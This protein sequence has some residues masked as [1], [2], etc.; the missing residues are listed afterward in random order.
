MYHERPSPGHYIFDAAWLLLGLVVGLHLPDVDSRLRWLV[1]SWLLLHR[2][3]LTHGPFVSLLL[4]RLARKRGDAGR[5]LRLFAVG[6]S[7]ALAV[8]F[9]FDFF[10]RGWAGFALIHVPVYGR[11]S[12]L[13]SQAWIVISIVTCLYAGLRLV[14]SVIESVLGAGGLIISFVISALENGEAI[15]SALLLLLFATTVTLGLS[16]LDRKR[17]MRRA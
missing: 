16:R 1:P 4:F 14:R 3:I 7:L 13:F 10:P 8:H 17:V 11:T 5:S 9:C 2:S 6:A 12:A 15:M